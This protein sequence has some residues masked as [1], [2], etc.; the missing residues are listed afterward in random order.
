MFSSVV[1]S[2]AARIE[3]D[4]D[5]SN[6]HD[7]RRSSGSKASTSSSEDDSPHL[8]VLLDEVPYLSGH[9]SL[10]CITGGAPS[11]APLDIN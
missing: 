7:N 11:C 5:V 8:P 9:S 10:H 6:I 3:P 4:V 1:E 2:V